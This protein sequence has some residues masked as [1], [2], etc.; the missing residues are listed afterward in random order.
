MRKVMMILP[1]VGIAIEGIVIVVA[2]PAEEPEDPQPL[3]QQ[4]GGIPI[5]ERDPPRK[6]IMA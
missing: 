2:A 5:Q 3:P 1:I 4:I 6:I